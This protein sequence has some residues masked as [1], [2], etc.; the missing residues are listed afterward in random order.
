M[1]VVEASEVIETAE[2]LRSRKIS[3]EDF[4]AIQVLEFSFILMF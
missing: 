2:G 3:T 1:E 4:E